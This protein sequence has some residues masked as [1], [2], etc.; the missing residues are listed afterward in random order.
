MQCRQI[1]FGRGQEYRFGNFEF[2]PPRQKAGMRQ[3]NRD[4]NPPMRLAVIS[5][6]LENAIV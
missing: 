3:R 4:S 6:P 5:T 2:E 1:G